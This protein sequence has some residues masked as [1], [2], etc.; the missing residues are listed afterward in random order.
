[1]QWGRGDKVSRDAVLLTGKTTHLDCSAGIRCHTTYECSAGGPEVLTKTGAGSALVQ[2]TEIQLFEWIGVSQQK[3]G[4]QK[5]A[6][7]LPAQISA[8]PPGSRT[9]R[10]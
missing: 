9:R 3:M 2:T 8:T 1:M 6:L 5:L 7:G 4:Q 10:F